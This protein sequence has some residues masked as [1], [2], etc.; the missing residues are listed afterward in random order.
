MMPRNHFFNNTAILSIGEVSDFDSFR[1]LDKEKHYMKKIGFCYKAID[2]D[3][4][5]KKKA[6]DLELEN[7]II[8]PFF[9]FKYWD[10]NI[11][12]KKYSGAYGNISFRDKFLDFC[13]MVEENIDE[14]LSGKKYFYINNL[15]K[16]AYYRDKKTM[17]K[18]LDKGGVNVPSKLETKSSK[19]LN[20]AVLKG[21]KFFIKPR[22]GSMGKG[23]TYLEKDN[24]QTNFKI[25]KNKIKNRYS[26]YGW[27]FRDV[28]NNSSFLEDLIKKD[29]LI[30]EA[31]ETLCIGKHKVDFRVYVFRGKV[32]YIYPR[33]NT[34]DS[35]TTNISQGGKGRPGIMKKVPER[36][37]RKIET[38]AAKAA[39]VLGLGF[40]G[41]DVVVDKA[42][43]KAYIVDVN[44]FPGLPRRRTYNLART[45]INDLAGR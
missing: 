19:K 36:V 37:V 1:K 17:M 15:K 45:I 25:R 23:I 24:W 9:P 28:T 33:I 2:Y 35:I 7:V 31:V 40:V 5:L 32:V 8:V 10:K 42:M 27:E 43:K 6:L 3:Y 20:E 13:D 18:K 34:S 30:E 16:C 21:G 11:E 4:V 44:M 38:Q 26:D 41:V 22:C 39:K 29:F 14:M 12:N